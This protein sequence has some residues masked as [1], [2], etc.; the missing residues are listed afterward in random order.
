MIDLKSTLGET[1]FPVLPEVCDRKSMFSSSIHRYKDVQHLGVYK[2]DLK[3][4][5]LFID[6]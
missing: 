6:S 3:P 5:R 1:S 2:A 4:S